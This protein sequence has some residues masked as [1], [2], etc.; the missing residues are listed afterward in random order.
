MIDKWFKY[1]TPEEQFVNPERETL[2]I[3]LRTGGIVLADR[4]DG[5]WFG[6]W[7]WIPDSEVKAWTYLI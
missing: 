6:M 3:R 1:T 4:I 2:L 5:H 7:K